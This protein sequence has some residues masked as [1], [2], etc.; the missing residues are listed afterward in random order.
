MGGKKRPSISQLEKRVQKEQESKTSKQEGG[1]KPKLKVTGEGALT[2]T[3]VDVIYRELAK[4]PYA[5]PYQV[6]SMFGIKVSEAKRVL[7]RLE[8]QGALKLLDAN[9]RVKIYVP[10]KAAS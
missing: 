6:S 2:Q 4:L 10:A 7:R 9:K 3:S 8:E 1:G 5:T